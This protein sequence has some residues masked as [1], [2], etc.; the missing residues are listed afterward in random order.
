MIACFGALITEALYHPPAWVHLVI[1]LPL[2]VILTAALIRPF[3]GVML[4]MQFHHKASEAR[5]DD[6]RL[7]GRG[8]STAGGTMTR[9]PFPLRRSPATAA[10][11]SPSA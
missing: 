4:A 11:C 10:P 1:W 6:R 5:H 2:T 9:G 8:P 7:G 3:K